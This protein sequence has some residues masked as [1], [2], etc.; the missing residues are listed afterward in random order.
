MRKLSKPKGKAQQEDRFYY[1]RN[2][3]NEYLQILIFLLGSFSSQRVLLLDIKLSRI[4]NIIVF[5]VCFCF[6]YIFP[7]NIQYT[8][9]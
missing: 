3:S 9:F 2:I 6:C 5:C 7:F 4:R 1:L 8:G